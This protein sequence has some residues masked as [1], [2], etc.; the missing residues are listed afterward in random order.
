VLVTTLLMSGLF[1]SWWEAG[2]FALTLTAALLV[3]RWLPGWLPWWVRLVNRVPVVVRVLAAV[4]ASWLVAHLV[5]EPAW[6]GTR[7]FF[8]VLLS[9]TVSVLLLA[10][11]L[12]RPI[13]R[14][15]PR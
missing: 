2:L 6:Y 10:V 12:P 3:R 7:S 13:E 5:I 8:P 15:A 1:G 14:Q 9:A 11:L 4:A